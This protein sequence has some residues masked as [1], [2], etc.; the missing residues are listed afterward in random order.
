MALQEAW[1]DLIARDFEGHPFLRHFW[2]ANYYSAFFGQSPLF[3]LT[4]HEDNGEMIG[5]MPMILG[6][7]RIAGIPLKQA[8]LIAGDHSHWNRI[9][10]SREGRAVF[11]AF[12]G[13]LREE[14]VDLIYLEDIPEIFPEREWMEEF[15]RKSR[16]PLEVRIVR[17]SPY[18][19][20]TGD[21]ETYRKKLSKKYRELLNNRLN[22]INR[23]GG[24][25][26]RAFGDLDRIDELMEEMRAI[27]ARSWQGGNDTGLF[28]K[29]DIDQFYSNFIR[30]SLENGYGRVYILYFEEK[31]TAFEFHIYSGTTEYCLKSEY[32]REIEK[33]SP[34]GVL[35]LELVKKAFSSDI[36]IYDLLGYEDEYKLRWTRLKRP[37][38]R[39]F[40]FGRSM[41]ARTAYWL[42][43][44][45]GNRLR[46][47]SLLRRLR[48][49]QPTA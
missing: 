18:M 31:P 30:H 36:E 11:E 13:R 21:F 35:D 19:P 22:R 29:R 4:A 46:K 10:I 34:G 15:C 41:A 37:Y 38:R 45:L 5:A 12:I 23:A 40:I 39:Y 49:R 7:R 17:R 9:P 44:R 3:I 27:S 48:E 16:L 28:S 32:S 14:G 47:S 33:L 1:D 6:N 8:S 2:F 26:I 43:Y 24:F 42:Y 20:T 25:E